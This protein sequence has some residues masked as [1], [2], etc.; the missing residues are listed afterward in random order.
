VIKEKV[1]LA[2]QS[3]HDQV[4]THHRARRS[5]EEVTRKSLIKRIEFLK[6]YGNKKSKYQHRELLETKRREDEHVERHSVDLVRRRKL[7]N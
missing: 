2:S 4:T 6:V 3:L 5:L 1:R 7:E